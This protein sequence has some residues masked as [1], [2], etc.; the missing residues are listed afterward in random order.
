MHSDSLTKRLARRRKRGVHIGGGKSGVPVPS[1]GGVSSTLR[2]SG[3]SGTTLREIPVDGGFTSAQLSVC[4]GR[5]RRRPAQTSLMAAA[6]EET[7]GND[8]G[9]AA[10]S[11]SLV[12]ATIDRF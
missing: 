8:G 7:D 2:T 1:G 11:H 9:V 4:R 12:A 5:L 10:K 6:A 3:I